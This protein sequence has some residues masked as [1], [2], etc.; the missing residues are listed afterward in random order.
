MQNPAMSLCPSK[1]RNNKIKTTPKWAPVRLKDIHWKQSKK[2]KSKI[3]IAIRIIIMMM[4]NI[5]IKE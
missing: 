1:G 2:N 3:K 5:E 4:K